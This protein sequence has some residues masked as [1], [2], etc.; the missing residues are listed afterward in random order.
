MH[1]NFVGSH[2]RAE[3]CNIKSYTFSNSAAREGL[4]AGLSLS[5]A[6]AGTC[7]R[8]A[9]MRRTRRPCTKHETVIQQGTKQALNPEIG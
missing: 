2:Q 5:L 3:V 8:H 9:F 6:A 1:P 4:A 7:R